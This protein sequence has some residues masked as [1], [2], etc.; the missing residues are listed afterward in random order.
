[1]KIDFDQAVLLLKQDKVVAFPTETVYGLGANALSDKAVANVYKAKQRPS[2]NPLIVHVHAIEQAASIGHFSDVAQ[3]LVHHFWPG[4][5]TIVLPLRPD[6]SVSTLAT[7]GLQT[8]AIRLPELDSARRLIKAVN[9]PLVAP[10]ANPSGCLSCILFDQVETLFES[11]MPVLWGEESQKGLESTI[12]D[13]TTEK[14]IILRHGVITKTRLETFLGMSCQEAKPGDSIKAP[15]MLLR[16]YAP[17]LPMYLNRNFPE[18]RQAFIVF[19]DPDLG[20]IPQGAEVFY[21][22]KKSSL[23]EAAS[24]FFKILHLIES[25]GSFESIGVMPLPQKG[26]GIAINDRLSRGA[27]QE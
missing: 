26:I 1:M 8:V 14:P 11:K 5:L 6:A 15:G 21:L 25:K 13:C 3:Q 9:F 24:N 12:V 16:H 27:N 4:P 7:A 2:V 22:S 19:G 20:T 10:S 18:N 17:T 23:E